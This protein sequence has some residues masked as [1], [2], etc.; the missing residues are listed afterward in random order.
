M[1]GEDVFE[2]VD[3]PNCKLY[4][5]SGAV[6]AYK[7]AEVWKEF[8]IQVAQGI[9][10]IVVPADKAEKVLIDGILYIALPDGKIFDA[11]GLQVK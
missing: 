8:D 10:D 6:E 2:Y 9:E 5:P 3:Q 1:L 7:A 11:H 4:V